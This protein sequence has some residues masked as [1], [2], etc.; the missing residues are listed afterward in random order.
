[1]SPD[2]VDADL[3][4]TTDGRIIPRAEAEALQ[5][6]GA[7]A[8][9]TAAAAQPGT[10]TTGAVAAPAVRR[11][12]LRDFILDDEQAI[13]GLKRQ[14]ELFEQ[15]GEALPTVPEL[16]SVALAGRAARGWY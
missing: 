13:L 9:A 6:T 8:R 2:L 11:Q 10:A 5:E 4:R 14:R 7:R 3:F 15:A 12:Q 16:G 1:M